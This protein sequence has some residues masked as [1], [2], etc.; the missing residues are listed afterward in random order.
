MGHMGHGV[1]WV[2]GQF[3]NGSDGSRVTKCD[4]FQLCLLLTSRHSIMKPRVV[5][6]QKMVLVQF[7]SDLFVLE[8]VYCQL[9]CD[10]WVCQ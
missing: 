9:F 5:Y 8:F 10:H 3:T 4:P 2:T 7:Y 6:R 1:T